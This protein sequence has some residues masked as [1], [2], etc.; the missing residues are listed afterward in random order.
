MKIFSPCKNILRK[1]IYGTTSK[2]RTNIFIGST[3]SFGFR[4][5]D[6]SNT[7]YEKQRNG[8]NAIKPGLESNFSRIISH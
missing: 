6:A 4:I 1:R 8:T 2:G 7:Q 5:E 3:K